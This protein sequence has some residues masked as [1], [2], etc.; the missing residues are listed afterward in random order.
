LGKYC[1]PW[2]RA[3]PGRGGTR[4]EL[5]RS[6]GPGAEGRAFGNL[7]SS[8]ARF[9]GGAA[10]KFEHGFGPASE[11]ERTVTRPPARSTAEMISSLGSSGSAM[12]R[13]RLDDAIE[14]IPAMPW[15]ACDR[16]LLRRSTSGAVRLNAEFLDDT[17][18]MLRRL[19]ASAKPDA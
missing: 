12:K 13:V 15:R 2:P 1:A 19:G 7:P 11:S 10:R 16:G 18:A 9:G 3:R 14:R 6:V 5:P 8:P 17:S 4:A